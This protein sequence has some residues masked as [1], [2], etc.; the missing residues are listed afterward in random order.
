MARGLFDGRKTVGEHL[1]PCASLFLLWWKDKQANIGL[2]SERQ[3]G[4]VTPSS[5]TDIV[6]GR[7]TAGQGESG[8]VQS[9]VSQSQSSILGR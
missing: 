1:S 8:S 9:L 4:T 2:Q 7:S 3:R 6:H 5:M